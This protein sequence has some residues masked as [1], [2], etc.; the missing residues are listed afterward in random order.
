MSDAD[1]RPPFSARGP[2][3]LGLVALLVLVGGFGLW[4]VT[5]EIAGAVVASGQ[6]EVEE[7]RQVVQHPD[8]GVVAEI[9]VKNGDLVAPGDVLV[10][11]DGTLLRSELGIVESQF[12][13]ILARRGRLEAERDGAARITFPAE[14]AAAGAER[15]G[16][17]ALMSGQ[18]RLFAARAETEA[19][20]IEQLARR[21]AQIADQITGIDAQRRSVEDQKRLIAAELADL[22]SLLDRGLTQ[23]G[24]V[25]ALEREQA[26]LEGIAGELDASRA[27]AEGRIT[28][29]DIEILKRGAAR[30]EEANSQLRDLGYRELELAE[31]RRSLKER[32]D[33]LDLRA[34]VGG[35]VHAMTV[36]TPRSVIRA[37]DPVLYIVPQD[38]PLVIAS[39]ISPIHIDEVR[40]GQEVTLRFAAFDSRTTPELLGQVS[41]VSPD[42]LVDEARQTSYYRAE[43][44]LGPDELAKLGGRTIIPGMP[45]EVFIRTGERTP[46]A[47]LVKPLAEYF[48]RAFRES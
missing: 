48:N 15:P 2:V 16:I 30:R 47:Y 9:R 42:A 23:A 20:E 17:A 27:E 4:S 43:I 19:K 7:N 41:R 33:R 11:L 26:R 22:R 32:I 12:Y 40:I 39:R 6:V 10:R 21:R 34:P 28:E 37:A 3:A 38:R 44:V 5:T 46:L 8:G 1:R 31:R 29:I 35:V 18:E 36:T 14:L 45:V 13:E 25:L 24:R